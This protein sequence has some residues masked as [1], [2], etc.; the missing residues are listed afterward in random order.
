MRAYAGTVQDP[1][2]RQLEYAVA[3][4]DSGNFGR[5]ATACDVA[6]P[7]LSSQIRELEDRLGVTLFERGRHGASVTVDGLAVIEQARKVLA[8]TSEL[9]ELA[10]DRQGDIV[11]DFGI[12]II[13]TMAPYMLPTVVQEVK[14]RY[15]R[16]RMR[17]RE[18][19]TNDLVSLLEHG[20]LD[21]GVLA[22]PVPGTALEVAEVFVDPFLLA[23]AEDSLYAG[24][25]PVPASMLVG[26]PLVLLEEGH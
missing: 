26:L 12:G 1:T 11:G 13:P 17:L 3:V 7:T 21:L 14:R 18:E 19:R 15:P 10:A 5:A 9:T 25:A 8:A 22:T 23:V 16:A 20:G 6:Q 4:A 2:L 24:D